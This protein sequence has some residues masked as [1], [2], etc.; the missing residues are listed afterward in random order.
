M[1]TWLLYLII[2]AV[3]VVSELVYFR[4]A[5]KYNLLA[6]PKGNT[7]SSSSMAR[8]GGGV[9]FLLSIILWGVMMRSLGNEILGYTP[10]LCGLLIVAGVSFW[11][12][13]R[14]VPESVL[15]AAQF[16]AMG[17]MFWTMDIMYWGLWWKLLIALVMFV[18]A[19]NVINAMDGINGITAGYSF[20]VLLPLFLLNHHLKEP[21]MLDSLLG[22]SILGVIV[23]GFYNFRPRGK[24]KT[25]AGSVGSMGIAFIMLF[26]IGKLTA[27][28]SDLTWLVF[29]AVYG[30]DGCLT[31]LHQLIRREGIGRTRRKHAYQLMA[32]ELG[33]SHVTVSLIYMGLQL[34]ISLV[35]I[36]LIPNTAVAHWT[37]L[38]VVVLVLCAAYILFIKK[39]F[40]LYVVY[41]QQQRLE[42]TERITPDIISQ[43]TNQAQTTPTRYMN[44]ELCDSTKSLSQR[45][46]MA[47]E[48]G[49]GSSMQRPQKFSETVVCLR[50]R[51]V[52]ELYDEVERR[53]VENIELSPN[54]PVV[55]LNIPAGQWH[56]ERALESGTVIMVVRDGKSE[57][58]KKS[59][60]YVNGH[61]EMS[62]N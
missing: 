38:A 36:Y 48:P 18:G 34:V 23:F 10:F 1:N 55:A 33:M 52:E 13:I 61:Y 58:K 2:A 17:L 7:S 15:V 49:S 25:L 11:K 45:M 47:I 54:G 44:Y 40:R 27:K 46:L 59:L 24:A 21:F 14:S 29:L 50:G 6:K 3:L 57:V 5:D 9:I 39:N 62:R 41:L 60:V 37:Y 43:L 30:V 35:M 4:I 42:S 26:A 8:R 53:N 22:V 51:L 28:T 12:E 19:M 16:I 31:V 20:A 32:K 56:R